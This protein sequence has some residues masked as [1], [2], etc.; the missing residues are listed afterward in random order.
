MADKEEALSE[1]AA[2]KL[3]LSDQLVECTRE[4]EV[5]RVEKDEAHEKAAALVKQVEVA[6][7]AAAEA[8]ASSHE[9]VTSLKGTYALQLAAALAASEASVHKAEK[10]HL[11][12]LAACE[13]DLQVALSHPTLYKTNFVMLTQL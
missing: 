7:A 1:A 13:S 12:R 6:A 11:P 2:E 10:L 3:K 4:L 5:T 8:V 9:Q